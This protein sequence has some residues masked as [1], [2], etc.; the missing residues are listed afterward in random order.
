MD[1]SLLPLQVASGILIAFIVIFLFMS[2]VRL[3]GTGAA[4]NR[5]WTVIIL[6]PVCLIGGGLIAAGLGLADW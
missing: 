3:W 5:A 6:V 4:A 1:Q 2:A